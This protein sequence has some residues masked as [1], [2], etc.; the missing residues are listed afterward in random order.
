METLFARDDFPNHLFSIPGLDFSNDLFGIRIDGLWFRIGMFA[1][2]T[3][4]SDEVK[5]T[6]IQRQ[7]MLLKLDCLEEI[8]D[9][10]HWIPNTLCDLGK[11]NSYTMEEEDNKVY[12][13][14]PFYQF[15]IGS[16]SVEPLVFKYY[17]NSRTQLFINPDIQLYFKL[18]EREPGIW[19]DPRSGEEVLRRRINESNHLQIIEIR[20]GYLQKYLY[21]RQQALLVGHHRIHYLFN[22]EKDILDTFCGK[23]RFEKGSSIDGKK[24]IIQNFRQIDHANDRPY[25]GRFLHLWFEILPPSISIYDPWIEKSPFNPHE[26]TLPTQKGEVAP[27]RFNCSA[28]EVDF[29]YEGVACKFDET[30][31][32]NQEVLS[33]YESDSRCDVSDS[34]AVNCG[35]YWGLQKS[36][37]RIGND[38][39][40][41]WVGDFANEVPFGEWVHWKQFAVEPPSSETLRG[42]NEMPKIPD[43]INCLIGNLNRLSHALEELAHAMNVRVTNSFW[44]GSVESLAARHLK[45]VYA[46]NASD[47]E[48]LARATFMSTLVI[49]ALAPKPLRQLCHRWGRDFH[50]DNNGK[51]LGSRRL[52]ERVTFSALL[53]AELQLSMTDFS[54]FGKKIVEQ[55]ESH[56]E[57][58]LQIEIDKLRKRARCNLA[59]LA[60]LYDL[61]VYGG[62]A[63]QPN[64]KKISIAA[65]KL[66]LPTTGWHRSHFM[67]LIDLVT[68][69]VT[70]ARECIESGTKICIIQHSKNQNN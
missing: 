3:Q 57:S 40:S 2:T 27:A 26:F 64:M 20:T 19:W 11:P 7:S 44:R 5:Q 23:Y 36:V 8:Y 46:T 45:M 69:S 1:D 12:G 17:V 31:Y 6:V 67:K 41:T 68:T 13:Y 51:P 61:R 24:V 56:V 48:F 4:H 29:D 16:I 53:L 52:L 39:L 21:V 55:S 59:P 15:N 47:D 54:K 35:V 49:D 60:F 63:H 14:D 22:P 28:E 65:T 50:K 32:F 62:L 33:K 37:S 70:Q 30:V 9:E 58:S 18:E 34:G 38:L 10:I 66:G 42:L 43:Q 25:I